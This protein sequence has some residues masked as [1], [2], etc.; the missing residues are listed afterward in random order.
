[1]VIVWGRSH[2]IGDLVWSID[3]LNYKTEGAHGTWSIVDLLF[4]SQ[5]MNEESDLDELFLFCLS[6][7][8]LHLDKILILNSRSLK[9][10]SRSEKLKSSKNQ[11]KMARSR[12]IIIEIG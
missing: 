2:V 11:R 9:V 6:R 12:P 4:S 1:M 10:I 5:K 3:P 8:E 7:R